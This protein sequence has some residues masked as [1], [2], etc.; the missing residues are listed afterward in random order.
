[1]LSKPGKWNKKCGQYV[2]GNITY[3]EDSDLHRERATTGA[4]A[5][6]RVKAVQALTQTQNSPQKCDNSRIKS[7]TGLSTAQQET[8]LGLRYEE[9]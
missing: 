2:S 7:E 4:R 3:L 8:C 6:P 1:M 5:Q 9:E